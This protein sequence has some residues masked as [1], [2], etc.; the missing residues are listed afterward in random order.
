MSSSP[1]TPTSGFSLVINSRISSNRCSAW[2]LPLRRLTLAKASSNAS[3]VNSLYPKLLIR[4]T[5]FIM[6]SLRNVVRWS[7]SISS[8]PSF[9]ARRSAAFRIPLRTKSGDVSNRFQASSVQA[10]RCCGASHSLTSVRSSM[11]VHPASHCLGFCHGHA[12]A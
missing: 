5:A 12:E 1:S 7:E 11:V 10:T 6:A 3:K 9:L 4:L 8:N 2:L